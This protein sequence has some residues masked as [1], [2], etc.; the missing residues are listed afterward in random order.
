MRPEVQILLGAP[1]P[2][3]SVGQSVGLLIPRPGVQ[4]PLG[5]LFFLLRGEPINTKFIFGS[6][7]RGDPILTMFLFDGDF[8]F[9]LFWFRRRQF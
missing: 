7:L 4:A 9:G 3:S 6:D 8:R 5:T 1:S 2:D